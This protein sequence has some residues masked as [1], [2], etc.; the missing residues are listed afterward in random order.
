MNDK[1]PATELAAGEPLLR[2]TSNFL[3]DLDGD[4]GGAH[5]CDEAFP[6]ALRRHLFRDQP[7]GIFEA[8]P[9]REE[10]DARDLPT[11]VLE[12]YF[13]K[14]AVAVRV[15]G[16]AEGARE[17]LGESLIDN[18]RLQMLGILVQKHV[19]TN[20][21]V[22]EKQAVISLKRAVLQCDYGVLRQEGLSVLRTVLRQHASE[23]SRIL[24]YVQENGEGALQNLKHP[25]HH[26]FVYE[27]LKIPQIEERLECMLFETV[28]E[29]SSRECR[30]DLGVLRQALRSIV[31]R[32]EFLQRFFATAHR[33]GE[34][35]NRG[36]RAAPRGFQLAS[37]ESLARTRSTRS[38]KHSLL[39]FVLALLPPPAPPGLREAPAEKA[40]EAFSEEDV[41]LL[42]KAKALK[43]HTVY[44][45]CVELVQSF[46]GMREIVETG[47]YTSRSTGAQVRIERRRKTIL[48]SQRE[49]PLDDDD[50]FHERM[51]AFVDEHLEGVTGIASACYEIFESYKNFAIWFDDLSSV[52]PPPQNEKDGRADLLAVLH[53]LAETIRTHREE[54]EQDGL[55]EM[56]LQ[57]LSLTLA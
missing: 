19:M 16:D 40:A 57:P 42:S 45:D 24:L 4:D 20:R 47:R 37:L 54:V 17:P 28:F 44:H 55:R 27:L 30:E 13:R 43:S 26:R 2:C 32:R 9:E 1:L 7:D 41:L 23:G 52:Y 48:P 36:S 51:R 34:A 21:G 50:R 6:L 25:L 29:E 39:H 49:A 33:L 56:V 35:L 12:A 46:H 5:H 14:R 38:P 15:G 53:R 31:Q 10:D 18:K 22:T 3:A 11:S 8:N